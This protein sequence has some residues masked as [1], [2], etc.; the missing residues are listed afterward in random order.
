[1]AFF[2]ALSHITRPY[3]N[4]KTLL[5]VSIN[6]GYGIQVFSVVWPLQIATINAMLELISIFSCIFSWK[7]LYS[8]EFLNQSITLWTELWLWHYWIGFPLKKNLFF[9]ALCATFTEPLY[10]YDVWKENL[11]I[12]Y[13]FNSLKNFI[14]FWIGRHYRNTI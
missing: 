6:L 2:L 5:R 13:T 9:I 11:Q 14:G 1:M 8:I 3:T 4:P 12:L 7:K 10:I